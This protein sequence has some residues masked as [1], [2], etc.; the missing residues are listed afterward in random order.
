MSRLYIIICAVFISSFS[1]GQ[2]ELKKYLDFAKKKYQEGDYIY[3]LT[4]YDKAMELDSNSINTLWEYAEVLRA[5]KDYPKAA[6]YYGKVY[7]RESG[8]VYP[9]SLLNYGLMLKQSGKYDEAL[10]VFKKARKKYRKDT[11]G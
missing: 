11:R 1:F 8:E 9:A 5:Y 6:F 3:S 2:Q 10:E 4:Y 7:S